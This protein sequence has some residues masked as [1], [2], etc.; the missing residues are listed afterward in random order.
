MLIILETGRRDLWHR[1]T[2]PED[3]IVTSR[4]GAAIN[5]ETEIFLAAVDRMLTH[6]SLTRRTGT[7][8]WQT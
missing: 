2:E 5:A 7:P 3:P 6:L 8:L 1:E 4:R